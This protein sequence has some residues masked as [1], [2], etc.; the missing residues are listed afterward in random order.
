LGGIRKKLIRIINAYQGYCQKT[1]SSFQDIKKFQRLYGEHFT[2]IQTVL[3]RNFY[4]WIYIIRRVLLKVAK[5]L[6]RPYSK[7]VQKCFASCFNQITVFDLEELTKIDLTLE[8]FVIPLQRVD[9]RLTILLFQIVNDIVNNPHFSSFC[10]GGR[11]HFQEGGKILCDRSFYY[12]L[13]VLD[14]FSKIAESFPIWVS[15][16]P[17]PRP[18]FSGKFLKSRL[19]Q[20]KLCVFGEL[21]R[22]LSSMSLQRRGKLLCISGIFRVLFKKLFLNCPMQRM[23]LILE[24]NF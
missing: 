15:L 11:R 16:V 22:H 24:D 14:A 5:K 1:M 6:S 2:K 19:K 23:K 4:H 17:V 13:R 12:S 8:S 3:G 20:F 18:I 7:R 21:G 10:V 9:L